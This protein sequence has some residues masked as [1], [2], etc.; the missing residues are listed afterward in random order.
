MRR[1]WTLALASA[2][3]VVLAGGG[4]VVGDRTGGRTGGRTDSK[5]EPS[6]AEVRQT[7][8]ELFRQWSKLDTD[9]SKRSVKVRVAADVVL[10]HGDCFPYATLSAMR[11]AVQQLDVSRDSTAMQIG[12]GVVACEAVLTVASECRTR[13]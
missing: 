9:D 7:A 5:G 12:A 1:G 3:A 2:V 6:C 10:V 11:A 13:P 8:E 4:Y